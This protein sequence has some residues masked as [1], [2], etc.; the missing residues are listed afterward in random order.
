M[1]R[2]EAFGLVVAQEIQS[3]LRSPMHPL[4]A[5]LSE[6]GIEESLGL[7]LLQNFCDEI[8]PSLSLTQ[9][10]RDGYTKYI[11]P[12][13]VD[14]KMAFSSILAASAS[15][16]RLSRAAISVVHQLKYRSTAFVGLQ[17]VAHTSEMTS[18]VSLAA[19][20]TL[21]GLLIDDMITCSREFPALV[22]LTSYWAR[23]GA[24]LRH[25]PE[26]KAMR[27]F[28]LDQILLFGLY[29]PWVSFSY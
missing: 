27:Q 16:T 12:L 11:L 6:F 19:L 15:H 7:M 29:L 28:L 21:L 20:T 24:S 9:D 18:S 17:T 13:A 14:D 2:S 10:V 25:S 1:S 26:Q 5:R 3:P 4:R 22:Q 23:M 8:I